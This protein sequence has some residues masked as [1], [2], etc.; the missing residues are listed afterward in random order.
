MMLSLFCIICR[1]KEDQHDSESIEHAE[2]RRSKGGEGKAKA[3]PGNYN[4]LSAEE[5]VAEPSAK[6][7]PTYYDYD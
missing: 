7:D 3:L 1:K 5:E 6:N 2:G 4:S